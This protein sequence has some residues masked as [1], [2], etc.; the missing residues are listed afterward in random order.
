M[1]IAPVIA[2]WGTA[3]AFTWQSQAHALARTSVARSGWNEVG[4]LMDPRLDEVSGVVASRAQPGIL[5]VHNDSGDSA[6]IFAVGT[7]GAMHGEVR[8]KGARALDWEDIA[9]GPGPTGSDR[10]RPWLYVGDVGDNLLWR[11]SLQV[12]RFPEPRAADGAVEPQRVELR[13]EDRRSRNVEA[14]LVDPHSG[15]LLLVTKVDAPGGA[16]LF[17]A[18][19]ADLDDG[20]ATLTLLGAV[21]TGRL[22]T[23]GDVSAD[24]TKVVLRTYEGAYG[25]QVHPGE[26]VAEALMRQPSRL[27]APGGQ[28]EAICF[29]PDASSWL[30]ISE[31]RESPILQQ[32][33][34]AI[35]EWSDLPD[36]W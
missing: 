17:R 13:F 20:T 36:F 22:V 8:V 32:P 28:S 5:W 7:D 15:D 21:P 33:V 3:P 23:G 27:D 35:P 31:G 18:R 9:I 34:P 16:Q 30:T 4:R 26:S 10:T 1:R 12:Y 14:M 6:R 19:A 25:W 29:T 2:N 24:G 11:R